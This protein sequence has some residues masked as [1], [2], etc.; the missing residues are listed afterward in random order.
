MQKF[1]VRLLFTKRGY[2]KL[3]PV[4]KLIAELNS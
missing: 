1:S 4:Y 3:D 2:S